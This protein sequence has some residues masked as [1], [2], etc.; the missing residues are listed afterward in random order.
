MPFYREI[1]RRLDALTLTPGRATA[2]RRAL[3]KRYVQARLDAADLLLRAARDGDAAALAAYGEAR[4]EAVRILT[5]S[6][7]ANA[8]K[9]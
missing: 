5:T 2:E 1:G 6:T 7:P 8:K 9:K 4:A 3:I